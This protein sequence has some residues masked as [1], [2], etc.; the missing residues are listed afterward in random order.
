[1]TASMPS[2]AQKEK[3]YAALSSVAAAVGLALFKLVI[4]LMTNSLGILAEAAHSAL[5]LAAAIIT[6]MAVRVSDKPADDEHLYGHGKVENLSALVETLLLLVTCIWIVYEAIGRLFFK[7]PVISAS[8][9]AFI[10]MAVSIVIDYNRSR[11]LYRAARKY[12]SQALEADAL[13]F[14]TDIW[15][16]SVVIVGLLGVFIANH[17]PALK[18]LEKTDAVAALGVALIVV[19]VSLQLGKRTVHALLDSAPSGLQAKIKKTVEALP[20]VSD[21]HQIRL[22]I[23][24]HLMFVD[25]HVTLDGRQS[26][27]EAHEL[28]ETIE[29]AI[30]DIAP[31]ADITVHPEPNLIP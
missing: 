5:D 31:E 6:F 15:S 8:V 24:G 10:V 11:M 4:G 26:L 19:G 16:S 13:H 9:W 7:S 25:V 23:S 27:N 28:T 2:Y 3:N 12:R 14:H 29:T 22:R 18:F 21:C 20:G 17:V 1:M 30:R